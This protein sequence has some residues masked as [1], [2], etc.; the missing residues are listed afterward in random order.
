MDERIETKDSR[1]SAAI[2][3]WIETAKFKG[4]LMRGA[5]DDAMS[6]WKRS[7]RPR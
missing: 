1:E 5:M 6:R 4:S 7:Q 3:R 2:T